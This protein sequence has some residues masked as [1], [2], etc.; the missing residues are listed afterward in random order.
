MRILSPLL[1]AFTLLTGAIDLRAEEVE[2]WF[3]DH[4]EL[5]SMEPKPR[6][7]YLRE[8]RNILMTFEVNARADLPGEREAAF[9]AL[10]LWSEAEAAVEASG[11]QTLKCDST[12]NEYWTRIGTAEFCI[13]RATDDTNVNGECPKGFLSVEKAGIN[14]ASAAFYKWMCYSRF[15]DVWQPAEKQSIECP[16]SQAARCVTQDGKVRCTCGNGNGTDQPTGSGGRGSATPESPPK[17]TMPNTY[18]SLPPGEDRANGAATVPATKAPAASPPERPAEKDKSTK[19]LPSCRSLKPQCQDRESARTEFFSNKK[20]ACVYAGNVSKYRGPKP[21]KY[22]CE[23]KSFV[24]L[25][26]EYK[27]PSGVLCNPLVFCVPDPKKD[28]AFC[29][30]RGMEATAECERLAP[31]DPG[32]LNTLLTEFVKKETWNQFLIDLKQVCTNDQASAKFHCKECRIMYDR[33]FALNTE[34]LGNLC[35]KSA[36]RKATKSEGSA[37]EGA[38]SAR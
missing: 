5:M 33:I 10:N 16:G 35:E 37:K 36:K 26:H 27:C 31:K 32:C 14:P 12:R 8:M 18:A 7:D 21:T 22:G 24:S 34:F 28:N 25:G 19:K 13:S 1:F 30:K 29:A 11:L 9:R 17:S 3:A 15:K 6:R 20:R 23:P 38:S 2:S 4:D